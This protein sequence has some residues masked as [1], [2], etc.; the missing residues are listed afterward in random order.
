MSIKTNICN[1]SI[2]VT[3]INTRIT[4]NSCSKK[5]DRKLKNSQ[6]TQNP[7]FFKISSNSKIFQVLVLYYGNTDLLKK[8]CLGYIVNL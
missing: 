6:Q 3:Q 8:K 5:Y 1:F 4:S 7:E 2:E